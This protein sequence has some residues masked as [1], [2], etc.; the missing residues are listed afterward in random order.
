MIHNTMASMVGHRPVK[1]NYQSS[2][3]RSKFN[4]AVGKTAK[5]A[6]KGYALSLVDGPVPIMD[7]LGFGIAVYETGVAWYE[8]FS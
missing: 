4:T 2:R 8:F 3:K 7:T 6:K 1:Q 5:A